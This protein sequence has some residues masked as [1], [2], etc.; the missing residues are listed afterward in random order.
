[1]TG[2]GVLVGLELVGVKM[3]SFVFSSVVDGGVSLGLELV[4]SKLI[5]LN[6][7]PAKIF[8]I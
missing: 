2:A 7:S 1:V 4:G 3:M 5:S 6:T 8:S